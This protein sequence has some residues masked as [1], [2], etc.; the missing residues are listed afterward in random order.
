MRTNSSSSASR[1]LR[2]NS[3][4]STSRTNRALRTVRALNLSDIDPTVT[5]PNITL[6]IVLSNKHIAYIALIICSKCRRSRNAA[7]NRYTRSILS[8]G[9]LRALCT[10]RTSGTLRTGCTCWPLRTSRALCALRSRCV[11]ACMQRKR[12]TQELI[13]TNQSIGVSSAWI[14]LHAQEIRSTTP[15]NRRKI[16]TFHYTTTH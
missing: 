14:E 7:N 10:S 12:H 11:I 4:S 8:C 2:T 15:I 5:I 16:S 6:A 9:T 13:S 1:T 3:T